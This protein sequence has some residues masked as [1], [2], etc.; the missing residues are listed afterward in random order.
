M[1]LPAPGKRGGALSSSPDDGCLRRVSSL[2]NLADRDAWVPIFLLPVSERPEGW[3][4]DPDNPR[5]HRYWNGED[6]DP[7]DPPS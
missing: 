6:W 2:D 1:R 3:Y 7:V 5:A 4:I